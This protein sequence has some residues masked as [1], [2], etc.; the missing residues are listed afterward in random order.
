MQIHAAARTG[1]KANRAGLVRA[2]THTHM[3]AQG[4]NIKAKLSS[5]NTSNMHTF[6]ET[7][8]SRNVF[9]LDQSL[10]DS[11]TIRYVSCSTQSCLGDPEHK[12][13]QANHPHKIQ[14]F[15]NT[16]IFHV[17]RYPITEKLNS[18]IWCM[19]LSFKILHNL[20]FSSD[21]ADLIRFSL[22]MLFSQSMGNVLVGELSR[23]TSHRGCL[24]K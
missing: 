14:S 2:H 4:R 13:N 18:K 1:K 11:H 6:S 20:K 16:D 5:S 9:L 7:L 3:H 12:L 8:S 22:W 19:H 15:C 10:S 21:S 17:G 23:K 24:S